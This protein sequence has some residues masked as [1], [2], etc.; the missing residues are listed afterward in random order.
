MPLRADPALNTTS[1][2]EQMP[3]N[4][5]IIVNQSVDIINEESDL[6]KSN[7]ELVDQQNRYE[8]RK[9]MKEHFRANSSGKQQVMKTIESWL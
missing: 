4:S 7:R 1:D 8:A 3:T 6:K 9:L 5:L 2:N